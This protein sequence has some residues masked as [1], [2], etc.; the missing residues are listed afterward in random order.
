MVCDSSLEDDGGMVDGGVN[1][2]VNSN[3]L[4]AHK[5]RIQQIGQRDVG[6][7][8]FLPHRNTELK[9]DGMGWDGMV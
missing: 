9:R 8:C 3:K 5:I 4:V 2:L 1:H 6:S 7:Q